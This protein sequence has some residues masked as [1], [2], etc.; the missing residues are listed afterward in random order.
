M[1]TYFCI[2]L[3]TTP[4]ADHGMNSKS[5][6]YEGGVRIPQF[7]HYPNKIS[8]GMKFDS[9]ISVIDTSATVLDYAGIT[10]SYDIDGQSWKEVIVD[11]SEPWKNRCLFFEMSYDRAVRCGC[12]KYLEIYNSRY[13]NTFRKGGVSGLS[14]DGQNL[15]NLCGN[16]DSYVTEIKGDNMEA[17]NLF[18]ESPIIVSQLETIQ[19]CHLKRISN[20]EFSSCQLDDQ[21]DANDES[22]TTEVKD[23]SQEEPEDPEESEALLDLLVYLFGKNSGS[24]RHLSGSQE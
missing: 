11:G 7:V 18:D 8:A 1:L 15:F 3:V 5:S 13:S 23:D 10:P 21:N 2:S 20:G 22:P 24:R 12:Y 19:R 4:K 14:H 6:L 9:P 16:S 17:R